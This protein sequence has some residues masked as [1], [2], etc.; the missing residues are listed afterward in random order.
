MGVGLVVREGAISLGVGLRVCSEFVGRG[1]G[2]EEAAKSRVGFVTIL[3]C[4]GRIWILRRHGTGDG[5]PSEKLQES[6]EVFTGAGR[7]SIE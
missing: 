4:F 1:M 6:Q 2:G 5:R 7:E 3:L